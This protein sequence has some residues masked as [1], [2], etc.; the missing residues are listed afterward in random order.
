MKTKA[1]IRQNNLNKIEKY[2]NKTH[3]IKEQNNK[4]SKQKSKD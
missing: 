3:K 4:I 2:N 1:H